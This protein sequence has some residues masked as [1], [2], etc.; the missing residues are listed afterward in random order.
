MRS[1][2]RK[3]L[4][5]G[6]GLVAMVAVLLG[7]GGWGYYATQ[8]A[9]RPLDTAKAYCADLR[10]H[11][12]TAAYSLLSSQMRGSISQ[13]EYALENTLRDQV[14]GPATAC[15]LPAGGSA[16]VTFSIPTSATVPLAIT[17]AQS[18]HSLT[19][20]IT[21]APENGAWR[22]T[23]IAAT[24]QGTDVAPIVTSRRFCEALVAGD[25]T[26]AYGLLST[27]EQQIG[28]EQDFATTYS[29]AFGGANGATK[30]TGCA[31]NPRAYTVSSDDASAT[32]N[33][34]LQGTP[35]VAIPTTLALVRQQGVWKIDA[36]TLTL[37]A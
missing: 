7:V 6:L 35:D 37:S 24:L 1:R 5:I 3:P 12:Y 2:S 23:S 4:I 32:L 25:Y 21:L 14:D 33:G 13:S 11:N 19:G 22:I 34:A 18:A 26:T 9:Q 29:Q 36:I 31:F 28:S 17:R 10:T 27:S 8:Q 16:G 20:A 30:L 15:Q